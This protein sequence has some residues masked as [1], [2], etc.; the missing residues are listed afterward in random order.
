MLS[1]SFNSAIDA[2]SGAAADALNV[3]KIKV[4]A[5]DILRSAVNVL[6]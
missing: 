3:G 1:I 5:N 2:A 6:T 4:G